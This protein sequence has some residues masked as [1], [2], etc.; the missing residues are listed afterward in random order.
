MVLALY[1]ANLVATRPAR[2]F[3]HAFDY[4]GRLE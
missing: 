2:L 1:L 4:V 3:E